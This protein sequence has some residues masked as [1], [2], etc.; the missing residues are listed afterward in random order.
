M[1]Q[2]YSWID[3]QN[4]LLYKKRRILIN[5]NEKHRRGKLST[6]SGIFI[7]QLFTLRESLRQSKTAKSGNKYA[8]LTNVYYNIII[9]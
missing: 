2:I 5:V 8:H 7:I 9:C 3:T 1:L 4:R 6:Y